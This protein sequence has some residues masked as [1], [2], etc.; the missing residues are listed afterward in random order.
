MKFLLVV[1][2]ILMTRNSFCQEIK[3]YQ[4]KNR[5]VI[6]V[7]D[8]SDSKL[9]K[10]KAFLT[11]SA[12]GLNERDILIIQADEA[13][14]EELNLKPSFSGLLLMGKDGGV[15]LKSSFI[16]EPEEL[17]ALIDRMPMRRAE[18]LR[19]KA[20]FLAVPKSCFLLV[21]NPMSL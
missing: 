20:S 2:F 5:L 18:I 17:F 14:R 15:K 1:F 19:K 6:L 7:G 16:V 12:R 10:Q 21:L 11:K 8:E 13:A 9:K 4:W 3:Q